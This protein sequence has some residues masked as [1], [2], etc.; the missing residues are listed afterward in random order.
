M[1]AGLRPGTRAD[2]PTLVLGLGSRLL[3]DD[4]VG[5]AV[6]E[7]LAERPFC[8][9]R[10]EVVET[11]FAHGL[12]LAEEANR[13]I[14]VDAVAAGGNPGAV[15]VW[16]LC[17]LGPTGPGL[18]LNN[19]TWSTFCC[20]GIPMLRRYWWASSRTGWSSTGG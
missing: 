3:M 1:G 12:A 17:E 15:N 5:I 6:V 20:S 10:Y 18:S 4:G 13:L 9:A 2:G 16:H 14:L 19:P 11:D 7:A 8:A